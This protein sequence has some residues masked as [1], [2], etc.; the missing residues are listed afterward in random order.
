MRTPSALGLGVLALGLLAACGDGGPPPARYDTFS[1]ELEDLADGDRVFPGQVI[2]F[3]TVYAGDLVRNLAW[4]ATLTHEASGETASVRWS[5]T[6]EDTS[7]IDVTRTYTLRHELL[8]RAGRIRI[9]V[10][11]S[12]TATRTGSAPWHA[13]SER[14]FVELR[15]TLDA[16]EVTLPAAEPLPYAT[17]IPFRVTGADLWGEVRVSVVDADS[18]APVAGLDQ[19]LPFDGTQPSLAGTLTPRARALEHVGT[20]RLR[21][22][23]RYGEL[24]LRSD[25][26]A[27]EVTHTIDA[28][29][30][31]VRRG[32][33]T[34]AAPDFPHRLPGV[35]ALVLRISGTQLAGHALTVNGGAP[36][37]AGGDSLDLDVH[38]PSGDDFGDG[39]GF[40]TYDLVVRSGG[41][42][43]SASVTLQ[44]WG[45]DGCGWRADGGA[46]LE[47]GAWTA[48][49]I[50]VV[51]AADSWGFPDT[52]TSWLV[53]RWPQA[54]FTL[55]EA[56]PG[57]RPEPGDLPF[58]ENNDDEVDSFLAD[59]RSG[60][61]EQRWTTSHEDEWDP[62]DLHMNAAEYYFE[63]KLEDQRCTSA[64]ILVPP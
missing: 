31:L 22:V 12:V 54:E 25:P 50:R 45:I 26:I 63:V 64:Q 46:A 62:L 15:P 34:L 60:R 38:A 44:R 21:L 58:L 42:E 48:R 39:E 10:R 19:A 24:E 30:A 14:V 35:A 1:V 52:T 4:E 47:D 37:L 59:V 61:S 33:G 5:D 40:R 2:R 23:A 29:S 9:Q 6:P 32:D 43:R 28:V 55:W 53:F 16:L 20:H 56:D 18:D 41:M 8:E 51:M 11:A 3:R 49:G 13:D 27:F 36:V 17:P 57:G 7:R